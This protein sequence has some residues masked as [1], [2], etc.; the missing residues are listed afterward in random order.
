[1]PVYPD[2]GKRSIAS[3]F[4][5]YA[6]TIAWK[7]AQR[8]VHTELCGV[9]L[10]YEQYGQQGGNILLL[11]GWGCSVQHFEP[12]VQALKDGYRLTVIDFPAHGESS[13]PPE[14][15]GVAEF[16]GC[17][18][19]LIEKLNIAPCDIIAHSFGGR[20]AL[21]LA[22]NE[23]QLVNRLVL[24]GCAGLRKPQTEEAKKRGE[25]YQKLKSL[26]QGMEKIRPLQGIA[27]KSLESLR[28]KYGSADYNALSDEMKKT[29]V[30]VINE[31]LSP[32]LPSVRAST[33]LI[34][35]ENDQDTPLWMGK[36]M[37]E[38]I[39]D[40]GLVVFENDDHFAYL[41]QWPRFVTVV[42]TFLK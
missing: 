19:Q 16:A 36:K 14:P 22:A 18:K 37:E 34:W 13:Q 2:S 12:I 27:Q 30:K 24:T 39:P 41:R 26:Y 40:A 33:L 4:C 21:W 17:V 31:D 10:H 9:S 29:F 3:A 23:P 8:A 25:R 7:G 35:G 38:E 5:G 42:R 11:H 1:M 32:L 15:W 28:R 6:I 20:V